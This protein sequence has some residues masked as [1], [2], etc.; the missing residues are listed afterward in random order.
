[1]AV[2]FLKTGGDAKKATSVADAEKEQRK[3]DSENRVRRFWLKRGTERRVTFLDGE[4]NEDG[5]LAMTMYYE[6]NL[7][8]NGHWRNFFVCTG[9]ESEPC[10][11]C[12]EGSQ[13]QLVAAFTVIDHTKFKDR[14]GNV[15]KNVVS[16]LIAKR[17]T[18]KLLEM[19]AVKRGGLAGATFDVGRVD[20]D[21]SAAVGSVFDYVAKNPMKAILNKFDAEGPFDYETILGYKTPDELR[22]LGFGKK[23]KIGEETSMDEPDFDGDFG[24]DAPEPEKKKVTEET[25]MGIFGDDDEDEV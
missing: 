5:E 1:M 3:K 23:A 24:E 15:H 16:L 21:Q 8:L 7:H 12:E 17:V 25:G 9:N 13:P 14:E 11:V 18:Q 6:H 20:E 4:L 22:K 2:T 10:P 19:Q